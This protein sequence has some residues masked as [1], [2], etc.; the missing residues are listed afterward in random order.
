MLGYPGDCFFLETLEIVGF[1][2]YPVLNFGNQPGCKNV[3]VFVNAAF[4]ADCSVFVLRR[5]WAAQFQKVSV[6]SG[7]VTAMG[8][9]RKGVGKMRK[10]WLC[11]LLTAALL[12]SLFPTAALADEDGPDAFAEGVVETVAEEQAVVDPELLEGGENPTEAE[13]FVELPNFGSVDEVGEPEWSSWGI[14]TGEFKESYF[15][16]LDSNSQYV[17]NEIL[18]GPLG[19]ERPN[20][21]TTVQLD[22]SNKSISKDDLND[23]VSPALLALIYDH[24][25]LSWLISNLP[26]YS[27]KYDPISLMVSTVEINWTESEVTVAAESGTKADVINAVNGAKSEIDAKLSATANPSIYDTLKAIHDYVC[28][29]VT[30]A[31]TTEPRIYQT[32]YSALCGERVT[33]CAGYAKAFK[34]ICEKY[35]I[36]CVLVSG[37]GGNNLNELQNHMWNYVQIDGAWY[38]VDCTWDDQENICYDYFLAGGNTVS[39]LGFGANKFNESH[40]ASGSWSSTGNYVF[41]YPDLSDDAYTPSDKPATITITCNPVP[42][43]SSSGNYYLIP[44]ASS[45]TKPESQI[46]EFSAMNEGNSID[47][48]WS[49]SGMQDWEGI[50]F[51]P[52]GDTAAMTITSNAA[53]DYTAEAGSMGGPKITVSAYCKGTTGTVEFGLY[54]VTPKPKFMGEI[55]NA[56]GSGAVTNIVAGGSATYTAKVYD[57]YGLE[58]SGQGLKWE[59]RD[60]PEGVVLDENGKIT[61]DSTVKE[62]NLNLV[63]SPSGNTDGNP[64]TA[65]ITI[66]ITEK[67]VVITPI[68]ASWIVDI[69]THTYTGKA[70]EPG[71]TLKNGAV[72]LDGSTDYTV[73]Y[74]KNT[75]VGT[76]TVKVT[77]K[78]NYSGT[79]EKNF[80]IIAA[81]IQSIDITAPTA[82]IHANDEKNTSIASL[83]SLFTLPDK[84]TARFAEANGVSSVELN[85]TWRNP[86]ESSFNKRGGRYVFTGT[87]ETGNNFKPYSGKLEAVVTVQPVTVKS[88]TVTATTTTVKANEIDAYVLPTAGTVEY[89]EITGGTINITWPTNYKETLKAAADKMGDASNTT[90]TLTAESVDFPDWATVPASFAMPTLTVTITNKEQA[91][92]TF[93]NGTSLGGIYGDTFAEPEVTVNIG[94]A[95]PD[96]EGVKFS[97]TGTTL[98]GAGYSS[99]EMP[100]DAGNYTVTATYEDSTYFGSA[101]M[102]FKIEPKNIELVWNGLGTAEIPLAYSGA[103][104][105]ITASIP[106]DSLLG[107]DTCT[108]TVTGGNQINAGTYTAKA[109]LSNKNYKATNDEKTYTIQKGDRNVYI[110]DD[111][112]DITGKTLNLYPAT[113]LSKEILVSYSNVDD[114][115]PKY[116]LT[117][118]ASAVKL[119][120]RGNQATVTAVGN[121]SATLTVSFD[122]TDNYKGVSVSCTIEAVAKPISQISIGSK[123]ETVDLTAKLD[124]STI[125]VV[126]LG[127][128]NKV[129]VKLVPAEDVRIT[130]EQSPD[131]GTV[132]A[133]G[134]KI[135]LKDKDSGTL[136]AEYTVDLSGVTKVPAGTSYEEAKSTVTSAKPEL[137]DTAAALA[138]ESEGLTAATANELI[139]AAKKAI[140]AAGEGA[141]VKVEASLQ[142]ELQDMKQTGTEKVLSLEIKPVYVV[143]TT[144]GG[145]TTTSETIPMTS[146][147]AASVTIKVTLPVDFPTD[148]LYAKHYNA[149]GVTVKEFIRVVIVGGKATWEQDSFSKTDLVQDTRSVTVVFNNGTKSE[150]LTFT[151]ENVGDTLPNSG[152]STGG[153]SIEGKTYTTL[154]DELLTLLVEKSVGGSYTVN[155]TDAPDTPVTPPVAPE[156]PSTPSTSGGS[157]GGGSSGTTN[158]K[159]SF[160]SSSNGSVTYTPSNPSKGTKV[161]LTAKPKSGYVLDTLRVLDAKGN[162]LELT[163]TSDGKYTFIMPDGKVTVDAKF[164]EEGSQTQTKDFPFTDAEDSWARDAIAWAYEN[165]YVNGTSATTFNPNGSITRQQMWMILARLSGASPA[166]MT[167][168]REWAMSSGV[169]DGTNGGNAMTRQQMVTFLYR[170]AQNRGYTTGGGTSLDSFPDNATVSA[171]AREPLAWAVGN[172]IVAGTSDGNLNPGGGA[173]RAQFAVILQRFY[174]NTV[175][176]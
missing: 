95:T 87:V 75:N 56:D 88:V 70:I 57:Q 21:A 37:K 139:D 62:T 89:N 115:D 99:A 73:E 162:E 109:T 15:D 53:K 80:T 126:G 130:L 81:E 72:T 112:T 18:N 8:L 63:V 7:P 120:T 40:V 29:T 149:D 24:P 66:N 164:A 12:L 92:V 165:G 140:E 51:T 143:K 42:T 4:D 14:T 100:K 6:S 119:T 84:T 79:V 135:S 134:G 65:E 103:P 74:S 136:I 132:I 118:N 148:N 122:E 43:E 39:S 27:Y 137:N 52:N 146:A 3:Y 9:E 173:T 59:L 38:A 141:T 156:K 106:A 123:D 114:V 101:S 85:V 147:L 133:N 124:G 171:Y 176:S 23:V 160:N 131:S 144:K 61:V 108:V 5:A 166:N 104:M 71:I 129:C 64:P 1:L 175:E 69:P 31:P 94:T 167:E 105:N 36:P 2:W 50:T 154:T 76:A 22:V 125:K 93:D 157:G 161:T 48:T 113:G 168:A 90:V 111:K 169:T 78:G 107:E 145:N 46:V 150:T 68:K 82:S 30:Y 172:G 155:K 152:T 49:K 54:K 33:V 96:K 117:G 20:E 60:T 55:T 32:A 26:G 28:N 110:S 25:E 67:P 58:M 163:K 97:Y 128:P 19:N 91:A 17:Y 121:G 10:K 127:D 86:A 16:Q 102:N 116:Q 142:V 138:P 77:G 34:L 83:K 170:Y 13:M 11:S 47:C 98:N 153:W 158:R 151:P 45:L 174:S 44:E 159:I 35:G 41:S